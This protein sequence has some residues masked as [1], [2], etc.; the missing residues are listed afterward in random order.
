MGWRGRRGVCWFT[1]LDAIWK[2]TPWG[3][4]EGQGAACSAG[5]FSPPCSTHAAQEQ[6]VLFERTRYR[7]LGRPGTSSQ[8][9]CQSYCQIHLGGNRSGCLRPMKARE[10]ADPEG[11]LEVAGSGGRHGKSRQSRRTGAPV[12]AALQRKIN[13]QDSTHP[14]PLPWWDQEGGDAT[15]NLQT[16]T[17]LDCIPL[18]FRFPAPQFLP[19]SSP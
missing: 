16:S 19:A 6:Q 3:G 15:R 11:P 18:S 4:P 13:T 17:Q 5:A 7:T 1:V 8:D 2:Q 14:T 12:G 9:L 10:P